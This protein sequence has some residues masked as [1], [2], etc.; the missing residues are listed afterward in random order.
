M[1]ILIDFKL[2]FKVSHLVHFAEKKTETFMKKTLLS[3]QLWATTV[4]AV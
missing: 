3:D 2:D 1:V 4:V